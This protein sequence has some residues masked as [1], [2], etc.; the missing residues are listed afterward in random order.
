MPE[1]DEPL[2]HTTLGN[3][4]VSS[5]EHY[6]LWDNTD[7]YVKFTERYIKDG[8]TVKESAHVLAKLPVPGMG[9]A[10]GAI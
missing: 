10:Q 4:P 7:T 3:V 6:V 5:L 2:I 1:N 8:V 9:S